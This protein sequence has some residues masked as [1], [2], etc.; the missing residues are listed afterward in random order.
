[1]AVI[2]L[3]QDNLDATI[4]EHDIVLIDFWAEWCGPCKSFA[5]VF[6]KVAERH[7][8]IA[9]GKLDIESEQAVAQQFGI[10]SIPTLAIFREQTLI[11]LEAGA[12]PESTLE[13]AVETVRGLDMEQVKAELAQR[14]EQARQQTG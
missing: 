4:R 3:T 11:M 8:D 9:F 14:A 13:Q 10:R 5:P 2:E 1:M 12:M 6:E 7:P